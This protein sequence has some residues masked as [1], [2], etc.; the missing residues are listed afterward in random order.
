[1]QNFS[2]P[3]LTQVFSKT[4]E[5]CR[6]KLGDRANQ[7][8]PGPNLSGLGLTSSS[9]GIQYDGSPCYEISLIM[10]RSIH[11]EFV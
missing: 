6:R 7:E 8:L 10:Q 2:N 5:Y 3:N 9:D 4:I 1:M 11:L